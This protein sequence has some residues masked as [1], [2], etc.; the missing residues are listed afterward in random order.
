MLMKQ[1]TSAAI[2]LERRGGRFVIILVAIVFLANFIL[3]A[4]EAKV[5]RWRKAGSQTVQL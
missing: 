3:N 4:I 1:S 5:I 2:N